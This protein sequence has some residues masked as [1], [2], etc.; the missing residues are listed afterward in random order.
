ME[1]AHISMYK[2]NSVLTKNIHTEWSFAISES[3]LLSKKLHNLFYFQPQVNDFSFICN[4]V[5]SLD[6]HK[7]ELGAIALGKKKS[8]GLLKKIFFGREIKIAYFT[9]TDT[10]L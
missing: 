4:W 10:R 2:I 3:G 5:H 7:I 9:Y 8:M 6:N 1:S